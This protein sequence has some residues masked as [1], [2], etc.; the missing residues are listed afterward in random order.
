MNIVITESAADD[1]AEG[2]L[3]YEEQTSGL[4]DYFESSILAD[5]RSLVIYAGIHEI[6]FCIYFRKIASRFPRAIYYTIDGENIEVHAVADTRRN[7]ALI[8][9]RFG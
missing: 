8:Q 5:M 2:Y 9:I 6:H 4:G 3:F 7:P 1:I